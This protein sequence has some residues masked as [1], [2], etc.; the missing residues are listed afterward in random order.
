M[1]KKLFK[2][3]G[4]YAVDLP[5]SFVRELGSKTVELAM[6]RDKVVIGARRDL[7]SIEDEPEFK[8]F[9]AA[10]LHDAMKRP[11]KLRDAGDVWKKE[12]RELLKDVPRGED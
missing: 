9:I 1:K 4:S 11:E 12:W 6:E 10:L 3:G 2:H 7:D 5:A 8:L